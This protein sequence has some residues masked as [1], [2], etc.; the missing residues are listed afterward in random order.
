MKS[1]LVVIFFSIV[2]LLSSLETAVAQVSCNADS[3]RIDVGGSTTLVKHNSCRIVSR[4]SGASILVPFK[5]SSEW[6]AFRN[7]ASVLGLSKEFCACESLQMQNF[8]VCIDN[9][10]CQWNGVSCEPALIVNYCSQ[11]SDPLSCN[12]TFGCEW[13]EGTCID[14]SMSQCLSVSSGGG[15]VE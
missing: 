4:S 9:P 15:P 3:C 10:S 2:T 11:N 14:T 7:S 8:N 12:Q 13:C 6:S 5:S 1:F